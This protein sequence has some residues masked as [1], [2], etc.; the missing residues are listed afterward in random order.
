MVKRYGENI[1]S[2]DGMY[3]PCILTIPEPKG[4]SAYIKK[5]MHHHI[6]TCLECHLVKEER[7]GDDQINYD[8]SLEPFTEEV[9]YIGIAIQRQVQAVT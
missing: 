6:R 8:N 5:E 9:S 7:Y 4:Q 2:D 3:K 1:K